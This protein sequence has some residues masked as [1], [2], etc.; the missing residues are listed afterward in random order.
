MHLYRKSP[1]GQKYVFPDG[2]FILNNNDNRSLIRI[3]TSLI[4]T[5]PAD[6]KTDFYC[7]IKVFLGATVKIIFENESL[8]DAPEGFV[9]E[10]GNT[11]VIC[12]NGQTNESAGFEIVRT[13]PVSNEQWVRVGMTKLNKNP[14]V[15]IS[16]NDVRFRIKQG[17]KLISEQ[18]ESSAQALYP[19]LENPEELEYEIWSSSNKVASI[20]GMWRYMTEIDLTFLELNN[21]LFTSRIRIL[22]DV[23]RIK[24]LENFIGFPNLDLEINNYVTSNSRMEP[25]HLDE[26]IQSFKGKALKL[27]DQLPFLNY[28]IPDNP[29]LESFY[30]EIRQQ[31]D[32]SKGSLTMGNY[33]KINSLIIHCFDSKS[34]LR[35]F[36]IGDIPL[37]TYFKFT[38]NNYADS[39]EIPN[40]DNIYIQLDN[41][42]LLNG[43][44]LLNADVA[45]QRTAASDTARQNLIDK[46]WTINENA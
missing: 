32:L 12:G 42:G 27:T 38:A 44:I 39:L 46:G 6:L 43:Q 13:R 14:D 31:T 29:N 19:E 23:K 9:I 22:H 4:I 37:L 2:D 34:D 16:F 18:P 10:G 20:G 35:D 5:V 11:F 40:P 1:K 36:S 8:V 33:P 24:G 25:E 7:T 30:F 15:G 26:I 21:D 17:S 28:S 3:N 45:S 41:N